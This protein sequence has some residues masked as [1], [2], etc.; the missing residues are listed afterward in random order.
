V[1][2]AKAEVYKKKLF[3]VSLQVNPAGKELWRYAKSSCPQHEKILFRNFRK[4]WKGENGRR[5]EGRIG[6]ER[7]GKILKIIPFRKY[8]KN[9]LQLGYDEVEKQYQVLE[10]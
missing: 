10:G 2:K 8:V 6:R 9:L 1:K 4:R 5:R 7:R 3:F